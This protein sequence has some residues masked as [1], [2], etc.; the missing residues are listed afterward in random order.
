M[1]ASFRPGD[2]ERSE[3]SPTEQT[4]TECIRS[5][6]DL[7][8]EFHASSEVKVAAAKFLIHQYER[9]GKPAADAPVVVREGG[10]ARPGE[11][12]ARDE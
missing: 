1:A 12:E 5:A 11:R 9:H 3:L 6:T 2:F 4:L 10:F 8:R 7:V